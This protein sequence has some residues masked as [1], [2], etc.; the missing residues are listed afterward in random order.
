M[1][2]THALTHTLLLLACCCCCCFTARAEAEGEK[3]GGQVDATE[4]GYIT[5]PGYPLEYPPHQNCEWVITAPEPSQRISLNFN[6]HFE[7]ERLD[8]RY[9]FIEIRDGNSDSA[10][11]LGRHCSN[12]A[13]S[14]IIS[15]GP[16]VHIKF[17]SDYAHQGAGFSLRYEIHKTVPSHQILTLYHECLPQRYC[18]TLSDEHSTVAMVHIGRLRIFRPI[19]TAL[20]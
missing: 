19:G 10:E 5:S 11:L 12:I 14:A 3:C 18:P 7:L 9:D 4:A 20:A 13:P 6:P 8:C 1:D 2:P 16:V 17:V 15:T